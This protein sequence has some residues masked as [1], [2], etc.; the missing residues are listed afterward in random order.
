MTPSRFRPGTLSF[1]QKLTLSIVVAVF[2]A[3]VLEGAIDS[4]FEHRVRKFQQ[5]NTELLSQETATIAL[6]LDIDGEEVYFNEEALAR[7]E[8][9]THFRLLRNEEVV[10]TGPEP[11]PEDNDE[12]AVRQ[13][14]VGENYRL[15][16]ARPTSRTQRL[17]QNDLFLNAL[18]LP[19]L[20]ALTWAVVS[21]LMR[22]AL[23]PI[24]ELTAASKELAR[25]HFAELITV[26]P[27]DDELSQ[28]AQSFNLMQSSIGTFLERERA[29]TRYASHELRTPLSAFKM[30][31][32]SLELGLSSPEKALPVLERNIVRMEAVLTA[33]LALARSNER[34]LEPTALQP[35]IQ[36]LLL[37]FPPELRQRIVLYD[38]LRDTVTV[39]D[40]R[41]IYQAIR[42][43]LENALR[44]SEGPVAIKLSCAERNLVVRICDRGPGVPDALIGNLTRPFFRLGKHSESLGLGLALVESIMRSLSGKLDLRNIEEQGERKGLEAKLTLPLH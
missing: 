21:L 43:L 32:E 38:E 36:E 13:G 37:S 44:Y 26:P 17:L 29:F 25:Q 33:L 18:D 30:Q 10:L 19:L 4:L 3:A 20:F 22:F 41:L 15:E 9:D 5:Q 2:V 1:R 11:F 16:I 28:M 6:A 31:V 14:F 40:A 8:P 23:Q 7:L 27:G 42:N 34:D 35:L 39:P 24:R 12:W